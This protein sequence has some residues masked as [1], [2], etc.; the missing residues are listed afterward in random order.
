MLYNFWIQYQMN[1]HILTMIF[2]LLHAFH[3]ISF[4]HITPSLGTDCSY[5]TVPIYS[6]TVFPSNCGLSLGVCW[7][8][9]F[10]MGFMPK[11]MTVV[12][13]G[14]FYSAVSSTHCV[15]LTRL[16]LL[17]TSRKQT[18]NLWAESIC[19][20]YCTVVVCQSYGCIVVA[21]VYLAIN[22]IG[23]VHFLRNICTFVCSQRQMS[24]HGAIN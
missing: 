3:E 2:T 9:L 6:Y 22:E 1:L 10:P 15:G 17:C 5:C 13:L 18:K 4:V 14:N 23:I 21:P 20:T 24:A 16:W 12:V 11:N 7:E 8:V 19:S